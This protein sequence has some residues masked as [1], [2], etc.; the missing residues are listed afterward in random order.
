MDPHQLNSG[1]T[2]IGLLVSETAVRME[3]IVLQLR[4][5]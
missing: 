1:T 3:R 4:V 5:L 2:H